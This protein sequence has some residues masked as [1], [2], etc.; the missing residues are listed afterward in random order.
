MKMK[1]SYIVPLCK[2]VIILLKEIQLI[3][4]HCSKYVLPSARGSSRPMSNNAVRTALRTLGY[5]KE[6]IVPHG[7]RT[8]AR[9]LLDE[10]LG[11][12]IDW[13]EQQL[14]HRVKDLN[15]RTYN[16]TKYLEKEQ[17]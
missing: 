9:T 11:Y 8:M 6:Q 16:R 2:Q 15:G 12:R 13:I 1:E 17:K 3:T 5:N 4:E 10:E 7:F 14:A